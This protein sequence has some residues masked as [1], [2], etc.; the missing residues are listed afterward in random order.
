MLQTQACRRAKLPGMG[1]ESVVPNTLCDLDNSD[2]I[3]RMRN[4]VSELNQRLLFSRCG[5]GL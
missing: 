2:R 5:G 4:L 1:R 3:L